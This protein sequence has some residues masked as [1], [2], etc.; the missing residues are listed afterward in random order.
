MSGTAPLG[1]ALGYGLISFGSAALNTLFVTY[2]L[3][4]FIAVVKVPTGWFYGSQLVFMVWNAVNDPLFGWIS[5]TFFN[6]TSGLLMQRRLRAVLVGG[7]LW[8]CAFVYVFSSL[9][10]HLMAGIHFGTALCLYDGM[11]TMVEV[12]QSALLSELVTDAGE[13]ALMVRSSMLLGCLGTCSSVFGRLYWDR[14][15]VQ[16]FQNMTL[17]LAAACVLVF[18]ASHLLLSSIHKHVQPVSTHPDRPPTPAL[19]QFIS[20]LSQHT[21]FRHFVGVSAVQQFDCTFE[22]NFFVLF[23]NYFGG[24]SL[25]TL[26][27]GLVISTSFVLPMLLTALSAGWVKRIGLFDTLHRIL[28][29]RLA[30]VL[31]GMVAIGMQVSGTGMV[32]FL[33]A[34]RIVSECCCR[35]FPLVVSDLTDEDVYL[36]ERESS[37]SAT[38]P[39]ALNFFSKPAQALAPM[40]GL[41]MLT[42][43][44]DQA[45]TYN[46]SDEQLR[47]L[48][49]YVAGVPLICV[50]LELGFWQS[51]S[52]RGSYKTKVSDHIRTMRETDESTNKLV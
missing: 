9:G 34:N 19:G 35:L 42:A 20:Q 48:A 32:L 37:M 5:D 26:G 12:N 43:Q 46:P 16:P 31:V 49:W 22:K 2:Y 47:P 41:A 44:L 8:A 30:I 25:S 50:L 6:K 33:L 40:A 29:A 15:H 38:I 39:G 27:H 14:E 1:L 24:G 7:I 51:Y 52:L 4:W 23:L 18:G 36:N 45:Q 11:L 21:N 13:R 17:L 3:D 10:N 28:V